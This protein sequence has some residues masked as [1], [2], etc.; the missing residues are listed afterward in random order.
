MGGDAGVGL[1]IG[2]RRAGSPIDAARNRRQTIVGAG[3]DVAQRD[4]G[5]EPLEGRGDAEGEEGSS[6]TGA[7]SAP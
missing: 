3:G 6:S 4:R 1:E 7:A 5:A 2:P